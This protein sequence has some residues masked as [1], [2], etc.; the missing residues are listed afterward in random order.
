LIDVTNAEFKIASLVSYKELKKIPP[1][2][3]KTFLYL[4][5]SDYL[6][7]RKRGYDTAAICWFATS[8]TLFLTNQVISTAEDI[9]RCMDGIDK[10]LALVVKK[11]SEALDGEY[12]IDLRRVED[13]ISQ[14]TER[15]DVKPLLPECPK[16]IQV[17]QPSFHSNRAGVDDNGRRRGEIQAR[18]ERLV[19]RRTT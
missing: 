7:E 10:P 11:C 13:W 9:K 12:E 2:Q 16:W 8:M 18:I 19:T 15:E 5:K 3:W 4:A 14:Y 17:R 1:S 6:P